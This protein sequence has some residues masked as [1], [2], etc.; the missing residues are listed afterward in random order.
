MKNSSYIV[1]IALSIFS[2][3]SL[4]ASNTITAQF[5]RLDRN[6]NGLLSRAET[7]SAPAL[8]SRFASYDKDKDGHLN[9]TEFAL[10]A[11]Q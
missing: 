10:Y 7:A 11:S 1:L 5:K 6:E 4:A 3:N 9:L 2:T 8:W